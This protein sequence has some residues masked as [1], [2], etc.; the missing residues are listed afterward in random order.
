MNVPESTRPPAPPMPSSEPPPSWREAAL[1]AHVS[2]FSVARLHNLGNFEHVRYEVTVEVPIGVRASDVLRDVDALL[3]ELNPK[4]PHGEY[5]LEQA[6]SVIA[7]LNREPAEEDILAD[8]SEQVA[9]RGRQR[10]RAQAV[11]DAE[12]LWATQRAAALA[13]LDAIGGSA[14]RGGGPREDYEEE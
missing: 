14:R 9:L 13:R 12:Q 1:A 8:S 2:R 10:Q 5:A 11:I 3:L 4:R 6:R 7:E